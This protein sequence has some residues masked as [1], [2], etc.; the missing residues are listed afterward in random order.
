LAT[1]KTIGIRALKNELSRIVN[2]IAETGGEY[3][4][5]DRDRPKAVLRPWQE[6]DRLEERARKNAE[7]LEQILRTAKEVAAAAAAAG[8]DV[9]AAEAVSEQRR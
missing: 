4:V 1:R 6:E 8:S 3:V 5:T 7:V 9:T 2:E